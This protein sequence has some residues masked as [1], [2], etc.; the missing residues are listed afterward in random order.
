MTDMKAGRE[1]D[2][3]VAEKVF[4]INV[5]KSEHK[6]GY[7][8]YTDGEPDWDW[9]RFEGSSLQNA[10]PMYS[11]DISDA[12]KVIE[13]LSFTVELTTNN[14]YGP[15]TDETEWLVTFH[16]EFEAH[17]CSAAHAICLAALKTINCGPI[18]DND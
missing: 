3:L 2:A 8:Y 1:L 13:K 16:A 14:P 10:I 6:N 4:G 18:P 17:G 5:V 7:A 11:T 15:T 12:W 9:I